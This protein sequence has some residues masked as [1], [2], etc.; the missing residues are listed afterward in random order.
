MTA[1]KKPAPVDPM[2]PQAP[3]NQGQ[4]NP[5][6]GAPLSPSNGARQ[7]MGETPSY[8]SLVAQGP[9]ASKPSASYADLVSGLGDTRQENA[10]AAQQDIAKGFQPTGEDPATQQARNAL[11]KSQQANTRQVLE[12]STLAGRGAT[13][14][15]QGDLEQHL[16]QVAAPQR[17]DFEATMAAQKRATDT[18][19]AQQAQTNF[20]NLES[21]GANERNQQATLAQ[22]DIAQQRQIASTEKLGFADLS[23]RE[24]SLTQEGQQFTDELAFKKYAADR[25]FT[26]AEAQ[27]VWQAV[28]NQAEISSRE[29]LGFAELSVKEKS[30]AQ[31][32]QQ[33]KD[34]LSFKK[35]ATDRGFTDA[36]A[37]RTW[38]AI[39]N[40]KQI[41]SQEKLG[42]AEL[43]IK[44]KQ[45][46]QEGQQFTDRL[47]FD[48]W[49]TQA[50]LDQQTAE[51]IWKANENTLDRTLNQYIADKGFDIDAKQLSETVR[52]FDTKQAFDKWATQAGI[53][54][55]NAELM[56]KANEND[57]ERKYNTG[58][59]ISTE[60][61]QVRLQKLQGDID[62]AKMNLENVL[63][64]KTL[65]QKHANDLDIE[66]VTNQYQVNRDTTA[67]NHEQAM[68]AMKN[69]YAAML[70][71]KGFDQ[72]T[73]MQAAELHA[74]SIEKQM[75]REMS[76]M[77]AK[78][79]LMYKYNALASQENISKEEIA[80]KRDAFTQEAALSLKQFG[81][82]EKRINSAIQSQQYQDRA[83]EIATFM[84]MA[85]DNKDAMDRAVRMYIDLLA[86]P[87]LPGGALMDAEDK[88]AALEGLK[89]AAAQDAATQTEA[90]KAAY[91]EKTKNA[92]DITKD[93]T[94]GAVDQLAK[95]NI[96][97]SLE[98]GLI[99]PLK[100]I[101]PTNWW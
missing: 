72:Q 40:E 3:A 77:E 51:R 59:R 25:G 57:I 76:T 14:Q 33:F 2:N 100:L 74:T 32:G 68:E 36:E 66:A 88:A 87:S 34:E 46:A 20:L 92:V 96:G 43:S 99:K 60:E 69:D 63:G 70:Q 73:A 17:M 19:R 35:Y 44:E 71:Q 49:A 37:Q 53:D 21:L 101:N 47:S 84:E 16:T 42:F 50:G 90:E 12:Q 98:L 7:A 80:L 75:D 78:A 64:L 6:T 55:Q 22:N 83:G 85:G 41:T 31:E 4:A 38:Q 23:L 67:M 29:K 95:G 52:Q 18:Q 48:K 54:Q 93:A 97:K 9:Q 56:W 1:P 79:E 86:D 65:E 91:Q 30:L 15:S 27:R 61:H 8:A 39:Q 26:D 81:L 94:V 45:I 13:G 11:I 62:T 5:D 82:D 89:T 58:E 10:Q 24:K 28:Q